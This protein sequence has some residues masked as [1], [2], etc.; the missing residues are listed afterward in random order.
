MLLYLKALYYDISA[1][2][3]LCQAVLMIHHIICFYTDE[4]RNNYRIFTKICFSA[5]NVD[6]FNSIDYSLGIAY[7]NCFNHLTWDY[8]GK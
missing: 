1:E 7:S 6:K 4:E 2:T 3:C 8:D 5:K